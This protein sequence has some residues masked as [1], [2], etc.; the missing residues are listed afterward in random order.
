MPR[1][2]SSTYVSDTTGRPVRRDSASAAEPS[3][4]GAT[5]TPVLAGPWVVPRL[6]WKIE[7]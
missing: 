1:S 3:A 5:S 7:K 2:R 6:C 4:D